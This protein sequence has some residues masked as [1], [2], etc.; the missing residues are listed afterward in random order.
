MGNLS[1]WW[2]VVRTVMEVLNYV[3]DVGNHQHAV[4]IVHWGVHPDDKLP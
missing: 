4:G 2:S 3:L 1:N